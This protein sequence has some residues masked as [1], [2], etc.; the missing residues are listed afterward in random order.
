MGYKSIDRV[1]KTL[2]STVKPHEARDSELREMCDMHLMMYDDFYRAF[3]PRESE[4]I[5]LFAFDLA[6]VRSRSSIELMLATA[7]QGYLIEP[8]LIARSLVE[9]FAYALKVWPVDDDRLIFS[10]KPQSSI[11]ALKTVYPVI[12]KAYGMLSS[13]AHYDP[14]MHLSF[15]GEY[16]TLDEGNSTVIQRSWIFKAVALAWVFFILDLKYKVFKYCYGG[17]ANFTNLQKLD[18]TI[19]EVFDRFFEGVSLPPIQHVRSLLA[20]A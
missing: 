12:G 20:S 11:S 17:Y 8:C 13:L 14:G 19:L 10:T 1:R 2:A 9:Q 16:D 18:G 3:T 5:G 7:R 6:L 15:I 4:R